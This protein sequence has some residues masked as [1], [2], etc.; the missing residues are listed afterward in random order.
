MVMLWGRY[1]QKSVGE[2]KWKKNKL[3]WANVRCVSWVCWVRSR[4]DMAK[5]YAVKAESFRYLSHVLRSDELNRRE[6]SGVVVFILMIWENKDQFD[7][8]TQRKSG[9]HHPSFDLLQSGQHK[10]GIHGTQS[11][12]TDHA[13]SPANKPVMSPRETPLLSRKFPFDQYDQ[14]PAAG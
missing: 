13:S 1:R 4:L 8:T 5:A 3:T 7:T 2:V 12:P 9:D 11:I 6:V 14:H 10:T